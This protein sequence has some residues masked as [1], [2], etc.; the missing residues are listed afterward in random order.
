[1]KIIITGGASGLGKAIT[2]KFAKDIS[3]T[4]FFTYNHS[5][6]AAI[7]LQREFHNTKSFNV[8]FRD[9]NSVESFINQ[10]PELAA[11][12]LVNNAITG[13]TQVHFHKMDPLLFENSFKYNIYPVIRIAQKFIA[14]SRK[15]K[16]GKIITILTSALINKPPVGFSEYVANKAYLHSMVKS[17]AAEN[18]AFGIQSNCISP[19][20]MQ[21]NLN[22]KTDSRVIENMINNHPN[23]Q[24]LKEEEV[25]NV[26]MFLANASPQ[27]NG[28]NI[29][30][31]AGENIL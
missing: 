8:D 20:F 22:S 4:V 28:N 2:K 13:Y 9:I 21:S 24:L 17:W 1:M 27:I 16:A 14:F 6:A 7:E 3:N 15:R 10:V 18:A 31:N 29:V 12:V 19:A 11:D 5:K 30:I 25:A 23:K 26:V